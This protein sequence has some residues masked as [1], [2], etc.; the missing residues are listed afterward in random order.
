MT[1]RACARACVCVC[2][3]VCACVCM[4]LNMA[5]ILLGETGLLDS[6]KS[7]LMYSSSKNG[8]IVFQFLSFFT[9]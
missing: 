8:E 2:V 6:N 3:C 7:Y 4:A 9:S 1:V 5:F